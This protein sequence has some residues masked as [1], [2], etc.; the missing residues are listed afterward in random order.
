MFKTFIDYYFP[1][2][3]NQHEKQST[4]TVKSMVLYDARVEIEHKDFLP[5]VHDTWMSIRQ[6]STYTI[7]FCQ[8]YDLFKYERNENQ[9][10]I[11]SN[12]LKLLDD[13]IYELSF[14]IHQRI[15][16]LE[17]IAEPILNEFYSKIM[18]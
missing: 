16:K 11:L 15:R 5:E 7:H 13:T 14:T 8:T 2:S 17:Q 10:Q 6:L 1:L 3:E 18:I 4:A 12:Q 9:Q